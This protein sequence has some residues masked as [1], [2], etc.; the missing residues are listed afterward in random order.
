MLGARLPVLSPLLLAASLFSLAYAVF[1][2]ARV[3]AFARQRPRP[4]AG[5]PVTVLKPLRGAE[6]SLYE[7]LRSFCEQDYP[8][9][10]V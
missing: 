1:A 8:E 10:Q 9:F 5:P 3:R 4:A 6:P 2:V 7:N